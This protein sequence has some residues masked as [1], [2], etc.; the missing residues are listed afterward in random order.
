M[1]LLCTCKMLQMK[2]IFT[3]LSAL[4][5]AFCAYSQNAPTWVNYG[6][7]QTQ[8]C[9]EQ[10]I[11]IAYDVIADDIDY[12]PFTISF[13]SSNT[14]LIDPVNISQYSY[15]VGSQI[16]LNFGAVA[17]LVT[18]PTS[19]DITLYLTAGPDV[20]SYTYPLTINPVTPIN[21]GQ[22]TYTLCNNLGNYDLNPLVDQTGANFYS[23][24]LETS[25]PNGI[26]DLYGFADYTFSVDVSYTNQYGCITNNY[27]D[28]TVV[29]APDLSLIETDATN[30][31]STDGQIEAVITGGA[32]PMNFVWENGNTTDVLRTGLTPGFYHID[33]VDA[34]GCVVQGTKDVSSSGAD[35]SANITNVNCHGL[36][37]GA[38]DLNVFGLTAPI[39]YLW[40]SG[41]GSEDINNL[42]A[43][44][45]TVQVQD[46]AGC[47]LFETFTVNQNPK[48]E[49]DYYNGYAD[50]NMMNGSV[51]CYPYGGDGNYSYL[52][53]N[54]N[55][56]Q[57]L[58]NI[59][60]GV[61]SCTV[62]DGAGC[63]ANMTAYVSNYG[64]PYSYSM[65]VQNPTC[66]AANGA[67]SVD[68]VQV[69]TGVG[70]V[71]SNGSLLLNQVNLSAGEYVFHIYNQ[72]GC[73]SYQAFNLETAAPSLQP[74]CV[75]TVDSVTTTN[76]VVWEKVEI[77]TIDYYKIYR[78]TAIPNDY[79]FIDTVH[80]SNISLF[81]DVVA[82]PMMQSWSYRISAV[83]ECGQEGPISSPHKTI[84]VTTS[85]LGNGS[86]MN[87]WNH[88]AGL[89]YAN[90]N[91][92]RYNTVEGWTL[93]NTISS[94]INSYLDAPQYTT[95][96]DYM[97]EFELNG[98]C[99]AD[100]QK[101]QDFNATRSNRDK[102]AFAAGSGT[103]DSNNSLTE[104]TISL[105]FYPNPAQEVLNLV[106]SSNAV[107]L[108]LGIYTV[109]GQQVGNEI[110]TEASFQMNVSQLS[111]G[112]YFL[113]LE[114]GSEAFQ[115]I[116]R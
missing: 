19:V 35:I 36:N 105:S 24:T 28:L 95:G 3:L 43:G 91:L 4:F 106:L 104:E 60:A 6:V 69:G 103:G 78:E 79:L 29:A 89:T 71:W 63:T 17:P 7:D 30:C 80:A 115:F 25:F 85:D 57:H 27:M 32:A 5:L 13:A 68:T 44:T 10:Y 38:I 74:I 52:W 46:A 47:N 11:S 96:L 98:S 12:Q 86:F 1:S 54:L 23:N 82:S 51:S 22:A 20:I 49:L 67:I 112:L 65:E 88:Y 113:R 50:C 16:H 9:S 59:P 18:T 94:S 73:H 111:E 81:N 21:F 109:D 15:M 58:N 84:H 56:T 55:T 31:T 93:V 39:T 83:N 8:G 33:V 108:S 97:V 48:L 37:T 14:L 90:Y 87:T 99:M 75:V 34:N 77:P 114:G 53:S 61:Y 92:Y 100:F 72:E 110:I 45:Y 2:K 66:G 70:F 40:S 101:A 26:I 76:L 64:G 107:G 41:H 62:T 116:K 102:G 42:Y